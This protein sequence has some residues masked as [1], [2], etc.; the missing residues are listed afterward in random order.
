MPIPRKFK[1]KSIPKPA[2]PYIT[3]LMP[4]PLRN[5][6]LP[7]TN[8]TF[9]KTVAHNANWEGMQSGHQQE[10]NSSIC[11]LMLPCNH[12]HACAIAMNMIRL[13]IY[14]TES[15]FIIQSEGRNASHL[16]FS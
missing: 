3:I 8:Y 13:R 4:L 15:S 12:T 9:L 14:I 16:W 2:L 11:R 5:Y 10:I 6:K 7:I 1:Y